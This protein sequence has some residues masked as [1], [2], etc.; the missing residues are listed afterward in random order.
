MA[1][2][3]LL[4]PSFRNFGAVIFDDI[5]EVVIDAKIISTKSNSNVATAIDTIVRTRYIL[6][7]LDDLISPHD[8]DLIMFENCTGAQTHTSAE[9]L[10]TTRAICV[11]LESIYRIPAIYISAADV[12]S[13][14]GVDLK[15]GPPHGRAKIDVYDKV[16]LRYPH[17][18]TWLSD[19]QITSKDRLYTYSDCM[20]IHM[21]LTS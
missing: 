1:L 20:A 18:S 10:F 8:L 14:L 16:C 2:I 4:D 12:K 6:R 13:R 7:E 19:Q 5:N 17:F 21:A 15:I 11:C 3:L 9:A